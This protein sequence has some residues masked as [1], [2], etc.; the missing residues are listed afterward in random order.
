MTIQNRIKIQTLVLSMLVLFIAWGFGYIY[1]TNEF[2]KSSD[3]QFEIVLKS[4]YNMLEFELKQ[5]KENLKYKL[6]E[7]LNFNGFKEAIISKDYKKIDIYL[8]KVYLNMLTSNKFVENIIIYSNDGKIL[9]S[10]NQNKK[11]LNHQVKQNKEIVDGFII[12]GSNVAYRVKKMIIDKGNNIGFIE[13]SI[14]AKK[15]IRNLNLYLDIKTG[16]ALDNKVSNDQLKLLDTSDILKYYFEFN[17]SEDFR[18]FKVDMQK[19]LLDYSKKSVAY[20]VIGYDMS[21]IINENQNFIYKM[22]W[23]GI[24]VVILIIFIVYFGFTSLLKYTTIQSFTD[25][26]TNLNNRDSLNNDLSFDNSNILILSNIKEFSLLNQYYG[27]E[28][29]NEVLKQ[30]ATGFEKFAIAHNMKTYRISADEYVLLSN[31]NRL[32]VVECGDILEELNDKISSMEI[33][34]GENNETLR[35]EIYSGVSFNGKLLLEEAQVALREAKVKSLPYLAYAKNLDNKVDTK[36]ILD[37]KKIIKHAI[38]NKNVIPF[39]QPIT[40]QYG[41]FIKYEALVRILNFENGNE[42]ILYPDQFLPIAIRS[43]LYVDLAK[44]MLFQSLTFFKDRDEKISVNFLPNDFYNH[45][46]MDRF[47]GLVQLY[48]YPER[49]VVEITEQEGV[50]DFDR[51]FKIVRKLR[52]LGVMIAIDDFGSGYANYVH[53]LQ[54]KPDYLKIDGSLIKN[55]LHDEDSQILVKSITRFAG[56]MKIKTVAEYVE[57]EDIFELLKTYGVD[58]F[59]GYYFGRPLNLILGPNIF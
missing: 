22:F 11:E 55:I 29:A 2:K 48:K 6:D 23:I 27:L 57:N 59:Q 54:I 56:Y 28:V 42:K 26:L 38:E 36:N 51:L 50:G 47:I 5:E 40:N 45:E 44:E 16:I 1:L 24:V 13:I 8:N 41:E 43:G 49:I 58:E 46:I 15:I 30:I 35:V 18:F 7:I 32:G 10:V 14:S 33:I 21:D 9:Y 20:L 25:K 39:F 17:K 53:I 4:A 19:E 37:I 34:V 12:N 3:K 52:K 31:D